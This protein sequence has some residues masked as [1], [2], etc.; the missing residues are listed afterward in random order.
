M[1][2]FG[3]SN[4]AGKSVLRPCPFWE[5]SLRPIRKWLLSIQVNDP[6]LAHILCK[7]IPANCPFERDI[8]LFG[9]L[10]FHIPPLCKLN[11]FYE[12]VVDLRF[13]ALVFLAEE[14]GEDVAQYCR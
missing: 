11:P 13:R 6:R 2:S 10:L 14:C 12:Q 5:N 3:T 7:L 9:H 1:V 4:S 8:Q